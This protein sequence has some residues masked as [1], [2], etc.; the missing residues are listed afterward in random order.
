L[1][2]EVIVRPQAEQDLDDAQRWYDEQRAG[3]GTEFRE[4]V[5]HLFTRLGENPL[6]YPVVYRRAHRAVLRRFPYLVY[7]V[8]SGGSV[9]VLACLHASRNP[10]IARS[11]TR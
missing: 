4:T 6:I 5:D 11:R 7:F 1:T 2:Y 9:I 8:V 3:L 10:R